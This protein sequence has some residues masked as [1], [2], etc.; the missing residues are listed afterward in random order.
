[1]RVMRR[2]SKYVII[3]LLLLLVAVNASAQNEILLWPNGAPGSEGKTSADVIKITGSN[4]RIITGVNH[5]SVTSYLP[6]ANC[7]INA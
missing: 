3:P 5:P 4:E 1:M 6:A 2:L 7:L